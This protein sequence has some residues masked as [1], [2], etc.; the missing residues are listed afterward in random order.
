MGNALLKFRLPQLQQAVDIALGAF[1]AVDP[2]WSV[3]PLMPA[4]N[5][6]LKQ[7]NRVVGMQ[8]GKN[9][10]AI[11]APLLPAASRCW[12]TPEPQSTR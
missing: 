2:V 8:V 4:R 10:A 12:V 6:Q 5:D 3:A 11:S 7:V 9:T 1:R